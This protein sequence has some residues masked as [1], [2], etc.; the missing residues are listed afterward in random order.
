MK[1]EGGKAG[2][3]DHPGK[4][5]ADGARVEGPVATVAEDEVG[6][7]QDM[8]RRCLF[9]FPGKTMLTEEPDQG[10]WEGYP[11]SAVSGLRLLQPEDPSSLEE[12]LGHR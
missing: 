6:F 5:V 9:L 1:V 10:R 2:I 3:V 12:G 4:R 7:L 8:S 11:S